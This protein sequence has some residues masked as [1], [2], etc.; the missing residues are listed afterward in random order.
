MLG[1]L[2]RKPINREEAIAI[3]SKFLA[4]NG[5]VVYPNAESAGEEWGVIVAGAEMGGKRW[6][7]YF[8]YL[9]LGRLPSGTVV[10]VHAT[11]GEAR[12][13]APEPREMVKIQ[14]PDK[15]QRTK[16]LQLLSNHILGRPDD[17]YIVPEAALEL[18][19]SFEIAYK[20]LAR[21]RED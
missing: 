12:F 16:A 14:I 8:R 3:A 15:K 19:D 21:V 4:A 20:E 10:T 11:T 13:D 7:V 2:F 5:C 6:R 18:L 17:A 1:W 9:E